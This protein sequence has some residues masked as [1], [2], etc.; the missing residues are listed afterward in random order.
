MSRAN[1]NNSYFTNRQDRYIHFTSQAR[2]AQYCFSFLEAVSTFSYR[3]LPSQSQMY[4]IHWPQ[5][6][7]HPHHIQSMAQ[8]ALSQFQSSHLSPP[9]GHEATSDED[10][11]VFPVLQAGQFNIREEERC[12]SLLFDYLSSQPLS[13]FTP[14]MDLTSGYF[15]LY[16]PY[17]DLILRSPIDC[18][19]I[20][21]GPK[22]CWSI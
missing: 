14:L 4:D 20:A 19:I 11:L 5:P 12:L 21:A 8:K 3:L 10:V 18:R 22:V 13:A 1:L 15:G 16:Q 9:S 2:L 6:H 17:Q 7:T